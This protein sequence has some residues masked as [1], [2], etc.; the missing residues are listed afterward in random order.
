MKFKTFNEDKLELLGQDAGGI[1][2]RE[3]MEEKILQLFVH[4]LSMIDQY[5]NNKDPIRFK[6]EFDFENHAD[7]VFFI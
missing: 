6:K 4:S 7:Y 1:L 3:L 2:I 5:E